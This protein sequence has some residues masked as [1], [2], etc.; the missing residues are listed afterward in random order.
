MLESLVSF[1]EINKKPYL[2]FIW[3]LIIS[4]VAIFVSRQISYSVTIGEHVFD[5]TGL[6]SVLFTVIPSVSFITLLLK[7]EE[8]MEEEYVKEHYEKAFW[9][10]HEKDLTVML[11]FFAGLTLSFAVWAYILPENF[12]QVQLQKINEI[13]GI[14]GAASYKYYTFTQILNNNLQVMFF[15]FLFSFIFGSGAIFII[16]WNASILGVYIGQLAESLWGIPIVGLSF[17]PHGLP[18]IAGYICAG[19]AGGIM[20]AMIIRKNTKHIKEIVAF[21]SIKLLILGTFLIFIAAIIEVYL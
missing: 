21:D 7:K 10:R 5:M 11:L 8:K 19:L 17:V 2:V 18:E 20:S 6:F 12:F 13:H 4:T 15:S 3:A 1:Q 16:A 9:I 14:S